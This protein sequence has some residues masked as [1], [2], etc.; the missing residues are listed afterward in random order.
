MTMEPKCDFGE[1]P[2]EGRCCKGCPKGQYVQSPCQGSKTTV[3]QPCPHGQFLDDTNFLTVCRRCRPCHSDSRLML[4]G[5]C[6]ADRDR[7]CKCVKGYYCTDSRCSHCRSVSTCPAG[8]GVTTPSDGLRNTVC[9]KCPEGQYNNVR[10]SVTPCLNH[11]RCEDLGMQTRTPG[12]KH[13]NCHCVAGELR[14]HWVLPACLW[15]GFILT[16]LFIGYGYFC[17]RVK[18]KSKKKVPTQELHANDVVLN[19]PNLIPAVHNQPCNGESHALYSSGQQCDSDF[20][21]AVMTSACPVEVHHP[22]KTEDLECDGPGVPTVTSL[23]HFYRSAAKTEEGK[24]FPLSPCQ[25]QPQEDE[26]CG[27]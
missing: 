24:D 10:D 7:Q 15:V 6:K 19:L 14:Y 20:H 5:E 17:W 27:T 9:Q 4:V 3:C 23:D 18:Q 11:T 2:H 25:S 1:F 26:W 13:S 16:V 12:T 22:L 21:S 8:F